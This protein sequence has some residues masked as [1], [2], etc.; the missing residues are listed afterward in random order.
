MILIILNL[1]W[2]HAESSLPEDCP[3]TIDLQWT[4]ALSGIEHNYTFSFVEFNE[5]AWPFYEQNGRPPLKEVF[6][7][8]RLPP[9]QRS[10]FDEL[11]VPASIVSDSIAAEAELLTSRNS[12]E[13]SLWLSEILSKISSF[14][15]NYL[16]VVGRVWPIVEALTRIRDLIV[17]SDLTPVTAKPYPK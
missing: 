4:D 3:N 8:Q 7:I 14:P 13:L 5:K 17:A 15:S 16:D 12:T 1:F 9:E 11:C 2:L 10:R 6:F